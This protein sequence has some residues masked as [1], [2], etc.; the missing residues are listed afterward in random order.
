MSEW[1]SDP[2]HTDFLV[3]APVKFRD[4]RDRPHRKR[5][6]S[7]QHQWSHPFFQRLRNGRGRSRAG[8]GNLL[9]IAG[10]GAAEILRFGDIHGYV[11][12]VAHQVPER[13][14]P[15]FQP[16]DTHCR[17][18]HVDTATAR[19]HIQR[20]AKHPDVPGR[21]RL[22]SAGRKRSHNEGNFRIG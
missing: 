4:A 5:M 11:A 16:G 21:Q 8:I 2:D 15:R 17:R 6:I 14:K 10:V 9:Q 13:F 18:T 19:A 22:S 3:H 20:H 7:A 12:A 1:A